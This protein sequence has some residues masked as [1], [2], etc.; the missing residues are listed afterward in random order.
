VGVGR[1]WV[2]DPRSWVLLAAI[3]VSIVAAR[4]IGAQSAQKTVRDKVYS[5][6]QAARGEKQYAGL[7]ANCHD[8]AKPPPPGKKAGPPLIGDKF[9]TNWDGRTLGELLTNI[10]TTMPNDG[11]AVLSD[12]E[13]ADVVAYVLKANGFP[14]GP[15]ALKSGASSQDVVIVK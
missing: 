3:L 8:P 12:E 13:T 2:L 9:L 11:S 14:D 6:D 10:Q 4:T 7:C 5:K 1:S 15:T